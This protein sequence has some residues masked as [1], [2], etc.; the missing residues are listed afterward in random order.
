MTR[1]ITE[2]FRALDNA[3]QIPMFTDA[4]LERLQRDP[5][6]NVDALRKSYRHA[7]LERVAR[8][9]GHTMS[10]ARE[11]ARNTEWSDAGWANGDTNE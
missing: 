8:T 10:S 3:D 9:F 1:Q 11:L 6:V 4:E 5:R 7:H 2:M